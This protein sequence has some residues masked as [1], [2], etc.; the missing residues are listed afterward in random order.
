MSLIYYPAGGALSALGVV[1][2]CWSTILAF[3][4]IS[5]ILNSRYAIQRRGRELQC[6]TVNTYAPSSL[7][8]YNLVKVGRFLETVSPYA[9][10]DLGIGLCI[11]LSVVGAA[12]YYTS[13]PCII[14][15]YYPEHQV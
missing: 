7:I 5:L 12:W 4:C 14:I 13:R 15:T 10:A 6:M 11:G 1:G 9:W 3:A 2:L 8:A